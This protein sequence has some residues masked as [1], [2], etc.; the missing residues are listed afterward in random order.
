VL[1][2]RRGAFT[3]IELMLAL[4]LLAVF[5]G[6]FVPVLCA[7]TRE[8]R[9]VAQEQAALQHAAN[10]LEDLTRRSPAELAADSQIVL[11]IP[12]HVRDML[13]GVE[14]SIHTAKSPDDPQTVEVAV[15]LR[16]PTSRETWSRT[17]R[18]AAWV[19]DREG[20]TP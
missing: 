4:G 2:G 11:E 13:P 9:A 16:W 7:I 10:V 5:C 20:G 15:S 17:V 8:R 19:R 6:V 12:K 3:I 14:Q 1:P 18:L